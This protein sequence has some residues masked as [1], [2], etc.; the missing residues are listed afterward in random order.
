[1]IF[2]FPKII[3]VTKLGKMELTKNAI[4]DKTHYGINIYAF[5]LRQYYQGQTVLSLS[6]RDC[7]PTKNPFNK[8][9]ETLVV[10]IKENKAYHEDIEIENFKGDV[11]SFAELHF[12]REG[13]ELLNEINKV[14]HLALDREKSFYKNK[15][16]LCENFEKENL[17]V[18]IPKCSYFSKPILNTVPL[19]TTSLLEIYKKITS[20]SF[21]IQTE[22][23]R[24]IQDKSS[25]RKYKA[26]NFDYVTFSGIFSKRNEADLILHSNLLVVDFDH[27]ENLADLKHGL[28]QDEYFETEL[29]FISP[30]GDGL[31]WVIPID[32]TEAIHQDYFRAVRNYIKATYQLE[33][34]QSGKDVS[35][36]CFLPFDKEAYINPKYTI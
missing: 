7:K 24:S 30:S 23:L 6:G 5:I 8:D 33:I 25:A 4:L 2:C 31:K 10:A 29:L 36:A 18:P 19:E 15:P 28:L 3:H 35:R 12:Q 13:Q 32:I 34:D 17:K 1:M 14:M 20:E 21:K 11:F 16:K 27:I 9:R 26:A 22:K